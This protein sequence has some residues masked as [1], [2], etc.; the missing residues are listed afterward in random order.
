MFSSVQRNKRI[1]RL[2]K[3]EKRAGTLQPILLY[4]SDP[5]KPAGQRCLGA[6]VVT[7]YGMMTA[8][9]RAWRL[10]INLGGQVLWYDPPVG[11]ESSYFNRLVTSEEELGVLGFQRKAVTA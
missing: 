2:V 3:E 4:F 10:G 1:A 6:C 5:D 8:I 11:L 9:Q 7:A